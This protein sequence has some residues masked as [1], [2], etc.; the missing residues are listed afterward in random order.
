LRRFVLHFHAFHSKSQFQ[1]S[2]RLILAHILAHI[3]RYVMQEKGICTMQKAAFLKSFAFTFFL[4]VVLLIAS[5]M[6]SRADVT[7]NIQGTVTNEAGQPLAGAVVSLITGNGAPQKFTTKADGKFFF[8]GIQNGNYSISA[9]LVTFDTG[10]VGVAVQQDNT[11]TVTLALKKKVVST[12]V[13]RGTVSAVRRTDTQTQY[14]ITQRT[15]QLTK[16]QPNNLYQFPGLTF[17]QPGVTPDSGGYTHIRGSSENQ[18]G[19]TYDG[20]PITRPTDNQFSTNLITVGL[21]SANLY[22]G[23][24]DASYGGST[25]GFINLV[26]ASGR[27]LHGGVTEY[28]S[29]LGHNYNYAGTNTQYGNVLLGGKLDYYISTI[30]F[31]NGFPGSTQLADL[32]QSSDQVVKLNY[33]SD[34]NTTFTGFFNNGLEVYNSYFPNIPS[35]TDPGANPNYDLHYDPTKHTAVHTGS[36]YAPHQTQ[37]YSIASFSIK[38]NFDPKSFLTFRTYYL[39]DNTDV[40]S[41][42]DNGLFLAT[43]D[44]ER[45]NQL[46]YTNQFN[47]IYQLRVGLAYTPGDALYHRISGIVGTTQEISSKGYSDASSDMKLKK[48]EAYITN[49]IKPMGDQLTLSLGLRLGSETFTPKAKFDAFTRNYADPRLGVVYSPNRDLVFRTSYSIQSQFPDTRRMMFLAPADLGLPATATDPQKQIGRVRATYGNQF[50]ALHVEH[51][52]NYDLGVEKALTV[53]STLGG[54]YSVSLTGFKHSQYNEIQADPASYVPLSPPISFNNNG[55]GQSTGVEFKLSKLQVRPSDW[56]GF[57][58]YTNQIA[59]ATSDFTAATPLV[60]YLPLAP[61]FTVGNPLLTDA[62]YRNLAGLEVPLNY[63]QRHTVAIVANKRFTKLFE[64]SFILDAG[65]GFPFAGGGAID[66]LFQGGA[67]AQHAEKIVGNADYTEVPVTLTSGGSAIQPY[68]PVVGR[69]GWHYKISINSNFYLTQDTNLFLNV[70]NVFDKLTATNLGTADLNNKAFYSAAT[71][72]YP[73]GQNYFGTQTTITPI[74]VSV[75][76]RHKF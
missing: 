18:V 53:P 10:I 73:Q 43:R 58:S 63:D 28:T 60:G 22:T 2:A 71:A 51:A 39:H 37:P 76:L 5:P 14:V 3:D 33:Y 17:G 11:S 47:P 1:A 75:G 54:R 31:R 16:S 72:Q 38:H 66:A 35:N 45:G 26:S 67:D 41:E 29:S 68:S 23:G 61:A 50:N 57:I 32:P 9:Q 12:G 64:S 4:A 7:G 65:S 69:T 48:Y 55:R 70:D 6:I 19:F 20:I 21:K 46:D 62:D 49:Q 56:N 13:T 52:Q 40:H 24:A 15:E 25:G 27:D 8:V 36:P 59:R 30:Q 42:T 74:F 34:P 44:T